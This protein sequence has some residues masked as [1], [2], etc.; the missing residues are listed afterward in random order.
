LSGSAHSSVFRGFR[1]GPFTLHGAFLTVLVLIPLVLG[2]SAARDGQPQSP[3]DKLREGAQTFVELIRARDTAA[4]LVRFSEQGTSFTGTAYVPSKAHLSPQEIHAD[5]EAKVGVYCLFFDTKCFQQEDSKA[6]TRENGRP[7]SSPLNSITDL[8]TKGT[9]K[10][11][12]TYNISNSN[13]KV[14]LLLSNRT[15]DTAR[16]GED[17]VNLY[18]RLENGQWKLRNIEYN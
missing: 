14:S 5:F 17:A 7:L 13:G 4:L 2:F 8:L 6:R 15:P 3:Q 1:N 10:R 11:F 12:V 18:F 9:E 16:L